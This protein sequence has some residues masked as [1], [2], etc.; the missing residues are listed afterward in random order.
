MHKTWKFVSRPRCGAPVAGTRLTS[1]F[2][3][4]DTGYRGAQGTPRYR[5]ILIS[6]WRPSEKPVARFFPRDERRE[7]NGLNLGALSKLADPDI[8]RRRTG[9]NVNYRPI[10]NG[11][12]TISCYCHFP[13]APYTFPD[14]LRGFG[15]IGLAVGFH[16]EIKRVAQIV[17]T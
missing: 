3:P 8:A 4:L 14:K 5:D 6:R 10:E 1:P 17:S 16:R 2:L 12:N 13:R 7:S 15:Q 11:R 9:G